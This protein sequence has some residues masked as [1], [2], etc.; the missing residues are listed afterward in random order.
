MPSNKK[1][2]IR[3]RREKTGE[4]YSTA[5][6]QLDAAI[7]APLPP[8]MT[9]WFDAEGRA[10]QN[11][12][13]LPQA[14]VVNVMDFDGKDLNTAW[15]PETAFDDPSMPKRPGMPPE[16]KRV[17]S[18]AEYIKVRERQTGWKLF[19]LKPHGDFMGLFLM[20]IISWDTRTKRERGER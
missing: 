5:R 2:R 19:N 11:D 7:T 9:E 4:S 12:G 3:E 15:V 18:L 8:V 1:R 14:E 17:L 10:I 13:S 6:K 16:T 20:A